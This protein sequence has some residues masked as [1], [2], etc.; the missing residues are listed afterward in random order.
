MS[1]SPLACNSRQLL[2]LV[3]WFVVLGHGP[4]AVAQQAAQDEP[5]LRQ[6][7]ER[8]IAAADKG[9]TQAVAALYDPAFTNV[10]V[11]DD[12]GL[13]RLS[14]EQ[15]LQ[16]LGRGANIPTKDTA[17]HHV[18]V[19]ADYGFVLLTRSKNLGSGWEPMFYSLVW[20]KQGDQWRLLREFV[21]QRS[22]PKPR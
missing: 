1:L 11:A 19:S 13:V 2:R 10:R 21:H 5:G 14:R 18:E 15:V 7:V 8:F 4:A 9:D 12:G 17:V 3:A 16:F 6:T 22:L 20:K